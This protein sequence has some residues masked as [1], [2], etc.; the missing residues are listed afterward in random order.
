MSTCVILCIL[1]GSYFQ[2]CLKIGI[3]S[4]QMKEINGP[5]DHHLWISSTLAEELQTQDCDED[6]LY[7]AQD[8]LMRC[9]YRIEKNCPAPI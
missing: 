2:E 5:G 8:W 6:N 3:N 4:R 1:S 9:Q 7:D